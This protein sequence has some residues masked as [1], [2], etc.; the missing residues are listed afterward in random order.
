MK[1]PINTYF[2]CRVKF[3]TIQKQM[4]L[5][6]A[7]C[8]LFIYNVK[9]Y[10]FKKLCVQPKVRNCQPLTTVFACLQMK[11]RPPVQQ[12]RDQYA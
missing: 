9:V 6:V 12:K 2:M 3:L 1:Q 7:V 8:Y 11:I 10:I 4:Y 5:L